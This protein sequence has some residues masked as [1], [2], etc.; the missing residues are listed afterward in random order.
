MGNSLDFSILINEF[1]LFINIIF[2]KLFF[3]C[4]KFYF[5]QP[6]HRLR[7]HDT[8]NHRQRGIHDRN[9]RPSE[10]GDT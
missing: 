4:G 9:D 10:S 1:H 6:V 2:D 5:N 8:I 3:E 7:T